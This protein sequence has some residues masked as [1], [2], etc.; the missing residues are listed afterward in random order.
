MYY[1]LSM[2]LVNHSEPKPEPIA[3]WAH[4]LQLYSVSV[5]E[6]FAAAHWEVRSLCSYNLLFCIR[7]PHAFYWLSSFL[8]CLL[9]LICFICSVLRT[10]RSSAW[11]SPADEALALGPP[12]LLQLFNAGGSA[13]TG[14]RTQ[15]SKFFFNPTFD[16]TKRVIDLTRSAFH[17]YRL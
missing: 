5:F 10:A 2:Y 9:L 15:R 13:P 3:L 6:K 4:V 8:F 14:T 17:F 1:T 12:F 11:D 7:G 16:L